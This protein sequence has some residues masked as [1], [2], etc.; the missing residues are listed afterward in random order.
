MRD[1]IACEEELRESTDSLAEI[2]IIDTE[3]S[4]NPLDFLCRLKARS[5]KLINIV[6]D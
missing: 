6:F 1:L 4:G 3:G 5:R 2:R